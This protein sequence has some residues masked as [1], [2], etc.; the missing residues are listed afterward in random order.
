MCE[1]TCGILQ[2]SA[3]GVDVLDKHLDG[4]LLHGLPVKLT[5][6]ADRAIA[7]LNSEQAL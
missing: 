6:H 1:L 3:D 5:T 4:H 2:T 7:G